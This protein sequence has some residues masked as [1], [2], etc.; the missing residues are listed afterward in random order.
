[1]VLGRIAVR[2]CGLSVPRQ[3]GTRTLNHVFSLLS[4]LVHTHSKQCS[5]RF[6]MEPSGRSR[7]QIGP[8]T[9]SGFCLDA[10]SCRSVTLSRTVAAGSNIIRVR[11]PYHWPLE[12]LEHSEPEPTRCSRPLRSHLCNSAV[13]STICVDCHQSS[14]AMVAH[15][16]TGTQR[17]QSV[18][19][20][21]RDTLPTVSCRHWTVDS[22]TPCRRAAKP[23]PHCA[24]S[25]SMRRPLG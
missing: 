23:T 2:C 24:A 1:M 21:L 14:R 3:P 22:E 25:V 6:Q 18:F 19:P 16:V 4:Q 10:A 11:H 17:L 9:G 8:T 7:S 5:I 13:F 12:A 15:A 20:G